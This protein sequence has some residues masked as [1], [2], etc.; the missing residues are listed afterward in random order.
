MIAFTQVFIFQGRLLTLDADHTVQKW[1]QGSG[2]DET[3]EMISNNS[4]VLIETAIAVAGTALQPTFIA[5]AA[6]REGKLK[7]VLPEHEPE[8]MVLYAVYAHRQLLASKVPSFV[9]F[10][11]SFFGEPPYWDRFK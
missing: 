8:P 11:D 6:I 9:D 7:V 3:R 1:L 2:R 10:I 5:G 4:D